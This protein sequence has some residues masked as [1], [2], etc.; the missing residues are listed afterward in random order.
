MDAIAF[1]AE[2]RI[3]EALE[4][5]DFDALP[6]AAAPL[7]LEADAQVPEELRMCYMLLK[8][9]GYLME[10]ADQTIPVR[11]LRVCLSPTE[12]EAYG[13]CLRLEVLRNKKQVLPGLDPDTSASAY[14]AKF[15]Q[16]I[17]QRSPRI[18]ED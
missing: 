15:A 1:V 7:V 14:H 11:N 17:V 6:G 18:G 10:E 13:C 9:S 3:R 12:A 16:K 5:G 4:R 2:Q 8:N